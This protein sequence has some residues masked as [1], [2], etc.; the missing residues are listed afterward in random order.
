MSVFEMPVRR[1]LEKRWSCGDGLLV[2]VLV[3]DGVMSR[4]AGVGV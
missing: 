1:C 3:C 4:G 2:R